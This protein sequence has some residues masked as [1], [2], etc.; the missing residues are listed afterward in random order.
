MVKVKGLDSGTSPRMT[1]ATIKG[2]DCG[3][4]PAM[5]RLFVNDTVALE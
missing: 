1:W 4:G 3:S 2:L 5:T